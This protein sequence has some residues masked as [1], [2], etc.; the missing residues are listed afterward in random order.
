[1]EANHLH[2]LMRLRLDVF[3]VEQNCVYPDLDGKDLD[4]IHIWALNESADLGDSAESV[5]RLLPP[6]LSYD[7]P[8]I[9]RVAVKD[10]QRGTG[11]GQEL[12]ERSLRACIRRW[13][14]MPI[15]ISAQEYLLNFYQSFGFEPYG[16]GYLEDGLPHMGMRMPA[17]NWEWCCEDIRK[18]AEE[19][20]EAFFRLSEEERQGPSDGWS[21][22]QVMSHIALSEKSLFA[23]MEKKCLA[24]PLELKQAD[25]ES[26]ERGWKMIAA[27]KSNVRLKAPTLGM[28]S[29]QGDDATATKGLEGDLFKSWHAQRMQGLDSWQAKVSDDVWW[30]V[31]IFRHPIAGY[32]SLYDTLRFMAE[33]IRHHIGQLN[34]MAREEN[35]R[36]G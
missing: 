27:L 21:A 1:M 5:V 28:L 13:P 23:Y 7:V 15:Q 14:L 31:Q 25:R 8:S 24:D 18:A 10:T 16:E 22:R 35:E 12:M 29:P 26:D 11:L 20:K 34:R 3:V 4:S 2:A 36:T 6:G 9:G 30:T 33:H 19:F 17:I 32:I